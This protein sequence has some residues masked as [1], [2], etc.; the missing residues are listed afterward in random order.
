MAYPAISRARVLFPAPDPP[1]TAV[2][3]PGR[4]ISEMLSSSCLPLSTTYLTSPH[5]QAAGARGGTWLRWTRVPSRK[6]RSTLPMVTTSS[7]VKIA[8]PTRV[9]LTNV[10]LMLVS[11]ISVPS[12]VGISVACLT[13]GEDVGDDDV[14]V[15]GAADRHGAG[16]I[17]RPGAERGESNFTNRV[18]RF[19]TSAVL[20]SITSNSAGGVAAAA[21]ALPALTTVMCSAGGRLRRRPVAVGCAAERAA[22]RGRGRCRSGRCSGCLGGGGGGA[23]RG[24]PE[25]AAAVG[26]VGLAAAPGLRLLRSAGGGAGGGRGVRQS[27][28]RPGW[29]ARNPASAASK[30]AGSGPCWGPNAKVSRGPCGFPTCDALPVVD[31]DHRHPVAVE[32]GPVQRAVVDRQPAA[33]VEAQDQVRAGYPRVG[34]AQ[35]GMQVAAD[36]HLVACGEGTLGPVVPDCQHRRG[37]S[38]HYSSIG[39][40]RQC[41]PLDS[42]VIRLCF[43]LATHSL[44]IACI[45]S[46]A[47]PRRHDSNVRGMSGVSA[48]GLRR[49]Q[50]QLRAPSRCTHP[51]YPAPCQVAGIPAG[52]PKN[53]G[54]NTHGRDEG[55]DPAPGRRATVC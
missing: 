38:T 7:S 27:R 16:R 45:G 11:R 41:A 18:A 43:D 20:A 54:A 36:D 21:G 33:L 42:P 49:A 22:A 24:G 55:T 32:I 8:D 48:A 35:V 17:S 30:V 29:A 25:S 47:Y 39:P 28:T 10:P 52:M 50:T 44:F 2:S 34:D 53:E 31:V 5:L 51:G 40:P 12:G 46:A 15:G 13:R 4:A 6:T 26:L 1:I 37:G 3:V 23:G 9:P 14:V 19:D